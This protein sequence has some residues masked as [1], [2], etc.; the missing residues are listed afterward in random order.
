[1]LLGLSTEQSYEPNK[2]IFLMHYLGPAA[3]LQHE[4]DEDSSWHTRKKNISGWD[5]RLRLLVSAQPLG[6]KLNRKQ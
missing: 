4:M 2:L 5:T 3:E 6:N 1:M